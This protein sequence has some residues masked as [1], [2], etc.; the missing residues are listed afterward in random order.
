MP[1]VVSFTFT[2]CVC[3][4]L[5]TYAYAETLV[6]LLEG[7]GGRVTSSGIVSLQEELSAI[8]NTIVALPLAQHN[9]RDAV[10]LI[11]QQK[12]MTDN[13]QVFIMANFRQGLIDRV[14]AIRQLQAIGVDD[15]DA[16]V[17]A[18]ANDLIWAEESHN[19]AVA[20]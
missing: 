20:E 17:A 13:F 12:Q 3:L 14:E 18:W 8:P 15:A 7:L 2:F 10:K 1:K 16:I 5:A 6:V 4:I 19:N 9:W 11:K